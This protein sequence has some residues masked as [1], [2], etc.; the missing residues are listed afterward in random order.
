MSAGGKKNLF[1]KTIDETGVF[2]DESTLYPEYLPEKM[3]AREKEIETI[4]S[5]LRPLAS[6]KRGRNLFV[7]GPP[8]TGKTSCIKFV[9]KELSEY[10]SMAKGHYINC[11]QTNTR[12][13]ILSEII[14]FLGFDFPRRGLSSEEAYSK[15]NEAIG[16]CGFMPIIVLDEFDRAIA[17]GSGS[18]TLYDL[19]RVSSEK[20]KEQFTTILVSND[21]TLTA[22]IDDRARSSLLPESLSYEKYT[23]MQLKE[24]LRERCRLAFRENTVPEDAIAL[25]AAHSAK[26]GGDARIAIESLLA[27]GRIAEK[28][29]AN[30]L[31]IGHLRKAFETV[32]S[33]SAVK[34]IPFL[35][36]DEKKMLEVV[37]ENDGAISGKIYDAFDRKTK[38]KL[39]E[40]SKRILLEKLEE[41]RLIETE[42]TSLGNEGRTRTI[43]LKAGKK[44]VM[45]KLGQEGAK[46]QAQ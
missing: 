14:N 46:K 32:D 43:K 42:E 33:A 13:G 17:S 9:L 10:T 38:G 7:F 25:A 45:E 31:K 4:A 8:G 22:R 19:L 5:A 28:E 44:A 39:A 35:S 12:Y 26:L 24:I 27:G 34:A 23:P 11:F 1:E 20:G 29:G 2:R 37:A 15:I 21:P 6:G 40:R 30:S 18:E 36:D 41:A 3:P 16:K